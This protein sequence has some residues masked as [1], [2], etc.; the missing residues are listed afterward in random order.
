MASVIVPSSPSESRP[1]RFGIYGGRYVPETLMAA[2]V[3][4]EREYEL[5]KAD[6]AFP[7]GAG[8]TAQG[9]RGTAD[10]ALFCQAADGSS[11]AARRST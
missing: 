4:L 11:W 10:A 1:G 9:L 6:S 2:L 3:E 8:W 5:A 7:D